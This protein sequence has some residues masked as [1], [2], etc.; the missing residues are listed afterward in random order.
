[1]ANLVTNDPLAMQDGQPAGCVALK[2]HDAAT[3]E[4]K[5][6]YVRPAYFSFPGGRRFHFSDPNG[7]EFAVWSDID[8]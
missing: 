4:L 7:N 3:C 2:G 8:A 1:M 5:R 6:L